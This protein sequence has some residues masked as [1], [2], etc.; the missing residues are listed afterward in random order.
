MLAN[1][2]KVDKQ[3]LLEKEL[4]KSM[5]A[6]KLKKE[7][8]QA[9]AAEQAAED[10]KFAAEQSEKKAKE[11]EEKEAQEQAEQQ[12]E[13]Q[14]VVQTEEQVEEQA[15]EETEE[16]EE[17]PQVQAEEQIQNPVEH[18]PP[19][20]PVLEP[21]IE[22]PVVE[23]PV[24]AEPI[25]SQEPEENFVNSALIAKE[26]KNLDKR[27]KKQ[28]RELEKQEKL[29]NKKPKKSK[30]GK[31][32]AAILILLLLAGAGVTW[33]MYGDYVQN[34]DKLL[35]GSTFYNGIV[36]E[37][38]DTGE[39]TRAEVLELAEKKQAE[40][41]PDLD[42]TIQAG[43][44][45]HTLT[46]DDFKFTYDTEKIVSEAYA[47]GRGGSKFVRYQK[48]KE[49]QFNKRVYKITATVDESSIADAVKKL[50]K[51]INV[52][53]IQPHVSKFTPGA[54]KQFRFV[55]GQTGIT[56]DDED[57]E[58][59]ITAFLKDDE[60]QGTIIAKVS[61]TPMK[62]TLKEVKQNTKLVSTYSTVSTNNVNGNHNMALALS[63]INGMILNPGDVFSFNKTTGDSTSGINGF[64][65]AGAISNGRAVTEYGG[66]ICQ[67]STTMYGA[68]V[69]ADL[70]IDERHNHTWP[71]T[72]VPIGQDASINYPTADLKVKND[73][74]FPIYIQAYMTGATLTI[75]MYGE[76]PKEYDK[77]E[78]TSQQTATINPGPTQTINTSA[79]PKG[80]TE[81]ER[82]AKIGKRASAFKI[83]YKNGKV[84][85]STALFSSY[86]PPVS[87]IIKKGT[88][89]EKPKNN[90][91]KPNQ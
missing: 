69:R 5:E 19:Q 16:V 10:A 20:E 88:K 70:K 86:Y 54:K 65:P 78:V 80:K 84:I 24:V 63:K 51:K 77:I 74:K 8:E 39:K 27:I 85:K 2:E 31:I 67:A 61:E 38:I 13:E 49:L 58:N 4:E 41:R 23:P 28:K 90:K 42:I 82:P 15:G 87:G 60:E 36:V 46:K 32:I 47:F 72:Y 30:K 81:V 1:E 12:V 71:S 22:E 66:G 33:A 83:Y 57:L 9:L 18:E 14:A 76:Q 3:S 91:P 79:L 11:Q 48:V 45:E 26:A 6:E 43:D 17:Q 89:V 40:T 34:A 62:Y 7:K 52:P 55:E 25:V 21:E 73:K 53:A 75:K 56:C 44:K 37:G 64:R 29:A 68:S 35:A 59:Q 50:K